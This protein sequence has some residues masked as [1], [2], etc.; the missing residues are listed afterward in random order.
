MFREYPYQGTLATVGQ[1]I[2]IKKPVAKGQHT[3]M[4]NLKGTN[5]IKIDKVIAVGVNGGG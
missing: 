3:L 4:W 5:K 1:E 2:T